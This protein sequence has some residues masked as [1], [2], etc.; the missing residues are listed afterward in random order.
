M[1]TKINNTNNTKP[2]YIMVQ[3]EAKNMQ[4]LVEKYAPGAIQSLAKYG[5]EMIA[6]TPA[7]TVL[8]GEWK[9]SWAAVLRF[10]S[11]EVA[12]T[13]YNSSEY[14]PFKELR[15]NEITNYNQILLVEGM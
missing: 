2:A 13:W 12:Q 9:G 11:I 8:E 4:D 7:P 14:K 1:E 3:V 5:G 15:I 10:P 6:G